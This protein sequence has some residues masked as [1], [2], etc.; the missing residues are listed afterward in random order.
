MT[1]K[2]ELYSYDILI[3]SNI[4]EDIKTLGEEKL[5]KLSNEV[6]LI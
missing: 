4:Q 5:K 1:I 6:R 2:N 3:N